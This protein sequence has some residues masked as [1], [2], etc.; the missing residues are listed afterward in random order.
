MTA[1]YRLTIYAPRTEDVTET[2]VLTPVAGAPHADPFQVATVAG[3]TGF[4][5]YLYPPQ[6]RSGSL[7][8]V[9]AETDVGEVTLQV[10]DAKVAS[11]Q[12]ERWVTAFFGDTSGRGR[13][14]GCKAIVEERLDGGAWTTFRT[15]RVRSVELRGYLGVQIRLRDFAQDMDTDIFRGPPASSVTY[16]HM[17][18]L[19]PNGIT[20]GYGAI[21]KIAALPGTY[22]AGKVVLDTSAIPTEGDY[23]YADVVTAELQAAF[24]NAYATDN[25]M[26]TLLKS[27]IV[28]VEILSGA[29]KGQSVDYYASKALTVLG[30]TGYLTPG[31]PGPVISLDADGRARFRSLVISQFGPDGANAY[32]DEGAAIRFQIL[33]NGPPTEDRPLLIDDVDPLVFLGDLLDGKFGALSDTGEPRISIPREAFPALTLPPVRFIATERQRLFEFVQKKLLQPR[34][35]ALVE[36]ADGRQELVDLRTPTSLAGVPTI[37]DADLVTQAPSWEFSQKGAVTRI[38]VKHYLDTQTPAD[39]MEESRDKYP[40]VSPARLESDELIFD[41]IHPGTAFG[42]LGDK[43]LEIDG[44]TF[45]HGEGEE[46]AG[47]DRVEWIRRQLLDM[48]RTIFGPF[49]DGAMEAAISMRRGSTA[50]QLAVGDLAILD[51]DA[52]PDPASNRR[53]G[54]RLARVVGRSERGPV[55]DFAFVDMGASAVA[56]APTIGTPSRTVGAEASSVTVPVTLNA[57]SEPVRVEFAVTA[58]TISTA[59]AETSDLWT[60][61]LTVTSTGSE[62]LANLPSGRRIWLRGRSEPTDTAT[63]KLPSPWVASSPAYKDTQ[64]GQAIKVSSPAV[65]PTWASWTL[66]GGDPDLPIDV[67]VAVPRVPVR[68][69]DF[70]TGDATGWSD[71]ATVLPVS[72]AEVPDSDLW[73][74]GVAYVARVTATAGAND[75]TPLITPDLLADPGNDVYLDAY[76]GEEWVIEVDVAADAATV[77]QSFAGRVVFADAVTPSGSNSQS[78][79]VSPSTARAAGAPYRLRGVVE[80]PERVAGADV[81]VARLVVGTEADAGSGGSWYFSRLRSHRSGRQKALRQWVY[82]SSGSAAAVQGAFEGSAG[83]DAVADTGAGGSYVLRLQTGASPRTPSAVPWGAALLQPA[84]VAGRTY[85]PTRPGETWDLTAWLS[86]G[87]SNASSVSVEAWFADEDEAGGG[88]AT[89]LTR[90]ATTWGLESGSVTVPDDA[91]AGKAPRW[92]AF[93]VTIPGA[94]SPTGSAYAASVQAERVDAWPDVTSTVR[95]RVE[96]LPAGSTRLRVDGLR[97]DESYAVVLSQRDGNGGVEETRLLLQTTSG[98]RDTAPTLSAFSVI[99]G[100]QA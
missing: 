21:P 89:V 63:A 96:V 31:Q 92:V 56:V 28:R 29:G 71:V 41:V 16:A 44:S 59:P 54:A 36:N 24:K 60:Y 17:A 49:G 55:I 85:L 64:G 10:L 69:P 42:Q 61:A 78:V 8:V 39:V 58:S 2:T 40:P 97:E 7:D 73:D 84:G 5:P 76:P 35:I 32:P 48:A 91:G 88:S 68:D 57:S 14:H 83:W 46:T 93:V 11:A 87:T 15:M 66:S 65:G 38:R 99:V 95:Q 77:A 90:T 67:E 45:R 51:V 18:P 81:A 70:D 43:V 79:T 82:T 98:A 47:Q 27:V 6:G 4:Q 30:G 23:A 33:H 37:T 72:D 25:I 80:A 1:D 20:R 75:E 22:S 12:L 53:G 100:D 19:L 26:D 52:L 3:L 94:G 62:V 86:R 9:K 50:S 34:R 74:E 13:I